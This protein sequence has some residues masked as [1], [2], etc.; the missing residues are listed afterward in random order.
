MINQ[1]V[2][3]TATLRHLPGD[4]SVK[5]VAGFPVDPDS[6]ATLTVQGTGSFDVMVR[7]PEWAKSSVRIKEK[8]PPP[9]RASLF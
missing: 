1:F 8:T 5:M 2:S 9:F 6:T 7:V 4:V 3:A